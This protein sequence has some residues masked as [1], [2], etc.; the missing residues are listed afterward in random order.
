[1]TASVKKLYSVRALQETDIPFLYS[2]Y[3]KSYRPYFQYLGN[4]DFYG[5][6]HR[7]MEEF[8]ARGAIGAVAVA[9]DDPDVILGWTLITVTESKVVVFYCYVKHAFRSL[10]IATTLMSQLSDLLPNQEVVFLQQTPGGVKLAERV[11]RKG[12]YDPYTYELK[13]QV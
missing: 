3:L 12:K 9:T 2:S 7:R 13:E 1:M 11:K 10:K 6:H 5:L 8:L 4:D